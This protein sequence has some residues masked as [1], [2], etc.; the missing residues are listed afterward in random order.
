MA[1]EVRHLLGLS[2]LYRHLVFDVLLGTIFDG[3]P[4]E[5][6]RYLLVHNHALSVDTTVH[7]VDLGDHADRANTLRVEASGQL[8]TV[9]GRHI[10]VGGHHTQ[11]DCAIV[12]HVSLAHASRDLFDIFGLTFN[13]DTGDAGKINQGQVGARMRVDLEHQGLVD[14]VV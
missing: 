2:L 13:W 5:S 14:D 8:K 6:Q 4:A 10:C 12:P 9:R 11:D 7:N 1:S 3:N